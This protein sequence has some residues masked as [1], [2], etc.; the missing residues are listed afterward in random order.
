MNRDEL[1]GTVLTKVPFDEVPE[2]LTRIAA[3]TTLG[4]CVVEIDR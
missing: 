3:R 4:K 1:R 2:A